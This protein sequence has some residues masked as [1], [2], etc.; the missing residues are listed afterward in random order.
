LDKFINI[1]NGTKDDIYQLVDLMNSQYSR[2]KNGEYFKWQF[3]NSPYNPVLIIAEIDKKIIGMFGLQKRKLNNGNLFG[4]AIDMLVSPE[5]RGKGIFNKMVNYALNQFTKLDAICVF[6]N[7]NGKN[8]VMKLGWKNIAKINDMFLKDQISEQRRDIE[9]QRSALIEFDF[10]ESIKKWRFNNHPEHKYFYRVI[11]KNNFAVTKIFR[12][13][14]T[15]C[16]YG[17]IVFIKYND[18]SLLKNIYRRSV[19]FLYSKEAESITTWALPHTYEYKIL[20]QLGF[21]QKIR[22]RYFCLKVFNPK[23][24]NLYNVNNWRLFQADAEIY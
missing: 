1:R 17:D 22:E 7:L 9:Y 13:P 4:Q 23:F 11:D 16:K 14:I 15:N 21:K 5:Y 20:I 18:K 2:K 10:N 24:N 3:F 19:S 8:A 12:D 6:P